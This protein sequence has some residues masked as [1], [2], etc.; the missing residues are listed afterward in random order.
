MNRWIRL[1]VAILAL[2]VAMPAFAEEATPPPS[3][4]P[5]SPNAM[6]QSNPMALFGGKRAISMGVGYGQIGSSW[7]LQFRPYLQLEF[8]KLGIGVA[9][10]I[11]LLGPIP[12]PTTADQHSAYGGVLR[13]QDFPSPNLNNYGHYLALVRSLRW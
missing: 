6:P 8:G 7:Y 12:R 13:S 2:V 3:S 1:A 10:P 9:L 11:N 4:P 5:P